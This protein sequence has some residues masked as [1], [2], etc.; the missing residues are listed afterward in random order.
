MR[1]RI[2]RTCALDKVLDLIATL[3]GKVCMHD[4]LPRERVLSHTKVLLH[5]RLDLLNLAFDTLQLVSSW[6]VDE[7][8]L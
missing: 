6:I 2:Q 1:L 4:E 7:E 8:S 3:Q 5:D